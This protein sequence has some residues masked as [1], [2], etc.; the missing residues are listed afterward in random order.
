MMVY[1]PPI[2]PRETVSGSRLKHLA[3]TPLNLLHF[4]ITKRFRYSV[5][6]THSMGPPLPFSFFF[7]LLIKYTW[8][9]TS[10]GL[11]FTCREV[12]EFFI[13]TS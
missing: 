3:I 6:Y 5:F 8:I 12:D 9:L 11:S 7:F 2:P 4:I 13:S 1:I 10:F